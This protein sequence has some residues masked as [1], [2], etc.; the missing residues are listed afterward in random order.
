MFTP[1]S[2]AISTLA[3]LGMTLF[4]VLSGF[5]IHYNYHEVC[6]TPGG[7]KKFFLAR[8]ARLYPLYIVLFAAEFISSFHM[9][10]GS[11]GLAGERWGYFL[12]LPYYL[13]FT[14]A[15]VYGV[16]CTN[17]MIYQYH[18][19]SAVTWSLSVEAFFYIAYVL[20][21]DWLRRQTNVAKQLIFAALSYGAGVGC[22]LVFWHYS[23]TVEH[24]ASVAFGPIA[25]EK[26]GYQDS[27]I[28]WLNY[29]NPLVNL[30]AFVCGAVAANIC[31]GNQEKPL[32]KAQQ[33]WGA[34]LVAFSIVAVLGVHFWIYL[35]LAPANAF[36]GRT[37]SVLYVPLV[38]VLVYALARYQDGICS[39][40]IG[41]SPLV[42]L[43]EASYSIY[44]LH[45]FFGWNAR[46]YYYLQLNPWLL[47]VIAI[48]CVII[49][50]RL[51][52]LLFERP[53]Q[54]WLRRKFRVQ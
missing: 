54:R 52:Y 10:R 35:E 20:G 2:G 41:S 26:H 16:I 32:E 4:F 30:P 11:C 14:Q 23:A 17:N 31:L 36:V 8:F 33:R 39:R 40:A 48:S 38:A 37:A 45:A 21:V 28:R 51:T 47:Y 7:N 24:V 53:V 5:V 29:F 25:T 18:M 6:A 9:Q 15:W 44:L 1:L 19:V 3:G 49:I 13:T 42:K 50:S 27:L 43:G 12:A 34:W 22:L 46:D